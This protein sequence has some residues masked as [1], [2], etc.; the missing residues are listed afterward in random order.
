MTEVIASENQFS[1]RIVSGE[2]PP[3]R[4]MTAAVKDTTFGTS[5]C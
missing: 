2:Q 5:Q 1:Y 4:F 3:R